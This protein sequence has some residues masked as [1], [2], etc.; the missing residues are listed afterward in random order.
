MG[1]V[2][3]EASTGAERADLRSLPL[4]GRQAS[5]QA[6]PS[7][8]ASVPH[9]WSRFP[10]SRLLPVPNKRR[11]FVAPLALIRSNQPK[12]L[13]LTGAVP[14]LQ[15]SSRQSDWGTLPDRG[16]K[17]QAQ[18]CQQEAPFPHTDPGDGWGGSLQSAILVFV[19]IQH[20]PQS[21]LIQVACACTVCGSETNFNKGGLCDASMLDYSERFLHYC[22][23]KE[24]KKENIHCGNIF[25]K[26]LKM[27]RCPGLV[28]SSLGSGNIPSCSFTVLC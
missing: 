16:S 20:F 24:K 13:F 8:P 26:R 25:D 28:E 3:E 5:T 4:K 10:S 2:A 19:V 18:F 1:N 17:A 11:E 9:R 6:P 14:G 7:L 12:V 15:P 22:K 27:L 21:A 23:K